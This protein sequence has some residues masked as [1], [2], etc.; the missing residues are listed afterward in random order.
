MMIEKTTA[1]NNIRTYYEPIENIPKKKIED[2]SGCTFPGLSSI[3]HKT[4]TISSNDDKVQIERSGV[5]NVFGIFPDIYTYD[6]AYIR[7]D[8][9]MRRKF[10]GILAELANLARLQNDRN[11]VQILD[12][13]KLKAGISRDTLNSSLLSCT[14]DTD[15]EPMGILLVL[16]PDIDKIV[17]SL[18]GNKK[19][20]E[21]VSFDTNDI[22]SM[23]S[24][25]LQ[26]KY[27][28]N[29]NEYVVGK[30]A[31]KN[32][33]FAALIS[34]KR[35]YAQGSDRLDKIA[36]LKDKIRS[37][38]LNELGYRRRNLAE[39]RSKEKELIPEYNKTAALHKKYSDE[40]DTYT[41]KALNDQQAKRRDFL[42][43]EIKAQDKL[44]HEYEDIQR[45]IK[46]LEN[47]MREI[48][49]NVTGDLYGLQDLV[50]QYD[51]LVRTSGTS[52]NKA[53]LL[54]MEDYI[55]FVTKQLKVPDDQFLEPETNLA[56]I[57]DSFAG[58][59]RLIS[60]QLG[61][62]TEAARKN[63]Q[64]EDYLAIARSIINST[65]LDEQ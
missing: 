61:V 44:I 45:K 35:E 50:L 56:R 65:S 40:L 24:G 3:F 48:K 7:S 57:R 60:A 20:K 38:F 26:Q 1:Q 37:A 25:V 22:I 19:S 43:T 18:L 32:P 23:I 64:R 29:V 33:D 9:E 42:G 16:E 62:K 53:E 59:E 63:L 27:G 36:S 46:I 28:T 5:S 12:Q 6:G 39:L 31:K 17:R 10:E 8:A 54:R 15:K 52:M 55:A 58:Q 21:E 51:Q 49:A 47:E 30:L 4:Y 14:P 2:H 41:G 13:L 34:L 11:L